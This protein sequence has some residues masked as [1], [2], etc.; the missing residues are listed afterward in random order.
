V[1]EL[2]DLSF[3]WYSLYKIHLVSTRLVI[4]SLCELN[5][6]DRDIA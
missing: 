6:F 2:I 4:K 3:E 5:S 1:V